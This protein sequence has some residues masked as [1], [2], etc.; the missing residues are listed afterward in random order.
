MGTGHKGNS[1]QPDNGLE[2]DFD[3]EV[4]LKGGE[5]ISP[6]PKG[7]KIGII[8]VRVLAVE[9]AKIGKPLTS[10]GHWPYFTGFL[11]KVFRL[12]ARESDFQGR[13]DN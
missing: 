5:F 3:A 11:P 4:L 9:S 10:G 7:W 8:E 12:L 1:P 13:R 2:V 6:I